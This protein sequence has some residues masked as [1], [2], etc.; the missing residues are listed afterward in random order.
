MAEGK[1]PSFFDSTLKGIIGSVSGMLTGAGVGAI[2]G[3]SAGAVIALATG[4]FPAIG[5]GA[6]L[7]ASL[8]GT[9][10]A[11]VGMVSGT[12]TGV[13]ASREAAQPTAADMM[14]VAKMAYSQGVSAGRQLEQEQSKGDETT[15]WRDRHAQEQAAKAIAKDDGH[16]IH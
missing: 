6:M 3:A 10:M 11:A 7:G 1:K 2:L 13:V 9:T 8:V 16:T 14:N 15:K 5:A 4:G 12:V